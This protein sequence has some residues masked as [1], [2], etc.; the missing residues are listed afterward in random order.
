[1][2]SISSPKC[3]VIR[4]SRHQAVGIGRE[5]RPVL[6]GGEDVTRIVRQHAPTI[7]LSQRSSAAASSGRV[8]HSF[9]MHQKTSSIAASAAAG[10][11]GN[12]R[13]TKRKRRGA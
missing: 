11:A 6:E 3:T 5:G 8:A 7:F 1:M 12:A 9:Q 4:P 2:D 10:S 13:L